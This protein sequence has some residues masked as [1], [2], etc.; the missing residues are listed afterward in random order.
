[1][2]PSPP[3]AGGRYSGTSW[4]CLAL[5][6]FGLLCPFLGIPS[7]VAIA[8]ALL[9]LNNIKKGHADPINRGILW[10]GLVCGVLG[11][12][13]AVVSVCYL[14]FQGA[15]EVKQFLIDAT[16]SKWF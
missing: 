2:T 15:V 4:W 12:L 11:A 6:I 3:I 9:E 8:L 13:I 14:L 16:H 7:F 10:I 5:G 1:M